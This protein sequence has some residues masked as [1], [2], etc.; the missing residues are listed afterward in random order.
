[1]TSSRVMKCTFLTK[2]CYVT[3]NFELIRWRHQELW[4]HFKKMY[5]GKY[6]NKLWNNKGQD[7]KLN[8][9]IPNKNLL[10]QAKFCF[11]TMTHFKILYLAKYWNRLWSNKG[12]DFKIDMHI[13]NKNSL[14]YAKFCINTMTSSRV[15][16][17]FQNTVTSSKILH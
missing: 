17:S 2:I 14:R 8:M 7:S 3:Q 16:M 6:R 1:M 13:S 12:Q 11:N 10:R 4:R 9:H 15:T 5:L